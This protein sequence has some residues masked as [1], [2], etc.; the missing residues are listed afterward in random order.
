M[1]YGRTN[2]T[3]TMTGRSLLAMASLLAV[4]APAEAWPSSIRGRSSLSSSSSSRPSSCLYMKD[5][6]LS[7]SC[8]DSSLQ[9]QKTTHFAFTMEEKKVRVTATTAA[10]AGS[11]PCAAGRLPGQDLPRSLLAPFF[12]YMYPSSTI[13]LLQV[14]W[15]RLTAVS[16]HE[17]YIIMCYAPV[18]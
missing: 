14:E 4:T 18:I 12:F 11:S 2:E 5:V 10:A 17:N 8:D 7:S 15:L 3:T 6:V 16:Q 1:N 9:Q 13:S